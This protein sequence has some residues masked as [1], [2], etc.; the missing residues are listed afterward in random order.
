M[1][2]G[3]FF[4]GEF[5]NWKLFIFTSKT[6]DNQAKTKKQKK[7]LFLVSFSFFLFLFFLN[8]VLFCLLLQTYCMLVSFH[9]WWCFSYRFLI[10][11]L[12]WSSYLIHGPWQYYVVFLWKF[13]CYTPLFWGGPNLHNSKLHWILTLEFDH[14]MM[15]PSSFD[16]RKCGAK[17]CATPP[18]PLKSSPQLLFYTD[19]PFF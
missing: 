1:V 4:L 18:R 3:F 10:L 17:F 9:L 5:T 15:W 8:N 13:L 16:A 11:L 12:Y 2:A 7:F 14:H 19:G 6:S